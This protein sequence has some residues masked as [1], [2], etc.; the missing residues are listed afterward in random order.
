[1]QWSCVRLLV[2]PLFVGQPLSAQSASGALFGEITRRYPKAKIGVA[3]PSDTF[4]RPCRAGRLPDSLVIL[5]GPFARDGYV[6]VYSYGGDSPFVADTGWTSVASRSVSSD[7]GE[8]DTLRAK[9]RGVNCT[10]A[11]KTV[12]L[13]RDN[14]YFGI[15]V[16]S[17]P[18][19]AE[20]EPDSRPA[21]VFAIAPN[22]ALY[23]ALRTNEA[24]LDEFDVTVKSGR[25]TG[26]ELA[27]VWW[28]QSTGLGYGFVFN[29][30]TNGRLRIDVHRETRCSKPDAKT[31]VTLHGTCSS[32]AAQ[33]SGRWELRSSGVDSICFVLPPG[34]K[35]WKSECAAFALDVSALS[36]ALKLSTIGTL[37]RTEK[38][39]PA[40]PY[41]PSFN[42]RP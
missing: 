18:S 9:V 3:P 28:S 33:A 22:G 30:F 6:N 31:G 8:A 42:N 39:P 23:M 7:R 11:V 15:D 1:M 27:G 34:E 19:P 25:P 29:L 37:L 21:R 36:S 16:S 10:D 12:L 5:T 26:R 35:G 4:A 38:T 17:I 14:Y 32:Y 20:I 40:R 41:P 13:E 2:L 24:G